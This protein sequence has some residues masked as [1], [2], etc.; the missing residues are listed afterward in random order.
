MATIFDLLLCQGDRHEKNIF[1]NEAGKITLIDNDES[2]NHTWRD[3]G[4][5]SVLLPTTQWATSNHVG[6]RVQQA[7]VN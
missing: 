1:I 3:V 6:K 7:Q 4:Q 2:F 5:D